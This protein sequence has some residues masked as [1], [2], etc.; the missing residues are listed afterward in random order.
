[1]KIQIVWTKRA[2]QPHLLNYK[3]HHMGS[4]QTYICEICQLISVVLKW[5]TITKW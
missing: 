4:S 1:M 5:I 2:W 3:T